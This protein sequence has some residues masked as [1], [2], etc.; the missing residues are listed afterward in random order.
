[1]LFWLVGAVMGG[2]KCHE[3]LESR[4]IRLNIFVA[5]GLW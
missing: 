4:F 3:C 5:A 1:M 2:F